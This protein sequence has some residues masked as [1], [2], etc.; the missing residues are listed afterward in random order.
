MKT[1][2]ILA[3]LALLFV[4]GCTAEPE[5]AEAQVSS[6]PWKQAERLRVE[7]IGQYPHDR[8]AFTQ[9]LLWHDGALYESTGQYGT[10]TL[11][12][13]DPTSGMV[14][15]QYNVD[16]SLFA[17]GLAFADGRFVQLTWKSG[18]ALVYDP[19]GLVP[20]DQMTYSGEG[21]GL[22][23]DGRRWLMSNG[24]SRITFRD[25]HTFAVLDTLDVTLNGVAVHNLNELEWAEGLI[26]AN[27]WQNNG[28]VRID[29][30]TG[31]VRAVIDAAGLLSPMDRAG[32]DVLNG[33]AY[34]PESRTFWITGK[35]WPWM[36]QVVFVP[37]E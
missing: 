28:I 16:P 19:A 1:R 24:T 36:F 6:K 3:C 18:L 25:P 14:L 22:T 11:R 10:S 2:P 20:I 23:W 21:W 31:K 34:D 8:R 33:I 37:A 27:V 30:E 5:P 17:E 15:E 26:Y 4:A 9:G 7:V 32:V 29:P 35:Y 13:V 12:R